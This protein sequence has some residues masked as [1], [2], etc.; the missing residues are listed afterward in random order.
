MLERH[1]KE[2]APVIDKDGIQS[3]V[4]RLLMRERVE[5][6]RRLTSVTDLC[7]DPARL[8]LPQ[9]FATHTEAHR[10]QCSKFG[11]EDLNLHGLPHEHLKLACTAIS[12]QL[13]EDGAEGGI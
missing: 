2:A 3:C 8:G 7:A 12:P 13:H 10:V 6:A 5:H 1:S 4:Y 9:S 11:G